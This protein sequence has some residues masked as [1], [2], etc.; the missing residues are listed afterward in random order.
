MDRLEKITKIMKNEFNANCGEHGCVGCKYYDV[1]CSLDYLMDA[2]M[3][4][5]KTIPKEKSIVLKNIDL[6]QVSLVEQKLEFEKEIEEF[7]EA[8]FN[9]EHGYSIKRHIIK[10]YFDMMQTGLGL[11]QK[12]NI[13]ADEVMEGY[14]KHL[15][16]MEQRGNKPRKKGDN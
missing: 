4:W 16:K 6:S 15:L 1:A 2:L 11:L 10:K 5:N 13:N 8:L 3:D 14:P 7:K 12:V 9:Y